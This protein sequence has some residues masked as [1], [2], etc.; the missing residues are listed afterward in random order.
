MLGSAH[1]AK[2]GN[3]I[4]DSHKKAAAALAKTNQKITEQRFRAFMSEGFRALDKDNF[5]KALTA[6]NQAATVYAN[7]PAIEQAMAQVETRRSQLWVTRNML[8][9]EEFVGQE[10]WSQARSVYQKL[11]LADATLSDVKV[12]QIP[13]AVRADLDKRIKL[14]IQDPLS[15]AASNQ[16]RK[17]QKVFQDASG[18]AKPGPLLSAQIATLKQLLT[19]S[20]TP[21]EVALA[22]DSNTDVTLCRVARLGSFDK[23]SVSLKPGRYIVAGT[24]T[25]FRDVRIEF[26]LTDKGFDSPITISCNEAI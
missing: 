8:R 6:F 21:I 16:Y 12:Q 4:I 17:A 25:G 10:K 14:I 3:A 15:L 1:H 18:I 13:V 23:T 11:L 19:T 24:R 26:T 7:H 22:S 9:A 2:E 20:Q 5:E